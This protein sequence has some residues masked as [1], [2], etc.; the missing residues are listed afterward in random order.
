MPVVAVRGVLELGDRRLAV[1][2][3]P[4]GHAEPQPEDRPLGSQVHQE[5]LP[6]PVGA[7]HRGAGDG[8][9]YLGR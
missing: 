6:D 5:Q 8:V 3:Q 4:P 9:R 1:D 2:H 7:Q